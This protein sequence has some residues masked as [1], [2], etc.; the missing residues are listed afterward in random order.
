MLPDEL[1]EVPEYLKGELTGANVMPMCDFC[2]EI[3]CETDGMA[4]GETCSQGCHGQC[5]VVQ[6]GQC[7]GCLGGC[8]ICESSCQNSCQSCQSSCESAAQNPTSYGSITVGE[9]TSHTIEVTLKAISK[10][11]SYVIAYR[12]DSTTTARNVETTLRNYT[13][14]SL[15]PN[16]RY[17]INYYGKNSYGTGP[18]M[19]SP[20]YATTRPEIVVEPWSW[21][22]SN[23]AATDTQTRN[24]YQILQ[25]NRAAD[26]FHHN[27]WNDFIDKIVEMREAYGLFW[28]TDS[29]RFP[30]A[31]GCKVS[32][33]DTLTA[34]IYNAAKT[35]IGSIQSTGIQ[36]VDP[37]DEITGYHVLHISDVLNDIIGG[38]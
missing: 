4:C 33:G 26:D 35:N 1:I 5:T 19:P 9:V 8:Q 29:G 25:G 15:E 16:Q 14:T 36:D 32:A 20:V 12:P 23:G 31:S 24:A 28:T 7:S 37:G 30:S 18:Y 6:C 21:T 13:L 17:V 27:V 10:A 3:A 2:T 38:L 22:S 34:E 11:T